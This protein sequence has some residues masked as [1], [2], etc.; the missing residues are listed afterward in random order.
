MARSYLQR[1][2]GAKG[3]AEAAKQHVVLC[4]SSLPRKPDEASLT[5]MDT[6]RVPALDRLT[7]EQA[8]VLIEFAAAYVHQLLYTRGLYSPELFRRHKL[9]GTVA[10]KSR[11]PQLNEYI[12]QA[13]SSLE[14]LSTSACLCAALP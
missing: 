1:R 2:G 11:H 14:V 9:Y 13:T 10:W 7:K 8:G 3:A 6:R 12:A 4:F 5:H